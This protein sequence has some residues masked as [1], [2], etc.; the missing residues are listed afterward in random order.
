MDGA[1]VEAIV[2]NGVHTWSMSSPRGI[3]ID[4]RGDFDLGDT[5][6]PNVGDRIY[7]TDNDNDRIQRY[8]V[9][10]VRLRPNEATNPMGIWLWYGTGTGFYYATAAPYY[11]FGIDGTLYCSSSSG[12]FLPYDIGFRTL[13]RTHDGPSGPE[14]YPAIVT[15]GSF[16]NY[17]GT[18]DV[19]SGY[20]YARNWVYNYTTDGQTTFHGAVSGGNVYFLEPATITYDPAI[21]ER[22]SR[23]LA[24]PGGQDWPTIVLRR[25]RFLVLPTALGGGG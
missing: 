19:I 12:I 15:K 6:P 24:P 14:Y 8:E 23:P 20:V 2:I 5:N 25:R 11:Y 3:A 1:N 17:Y 9:N 18:R 10:T 22:P 16:Y 7:W 4:M 21:A 13:P